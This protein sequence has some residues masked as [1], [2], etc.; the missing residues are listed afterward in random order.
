MSDSQLRRYITASDRLCTKYFDAKAGHLLARHLLQRRRLY[1]H[2][3]E[4]GDWRT[5]LAVLRDE[6]ELERLYPTAGKTEE[7][8][9]A[10]PPEPEELTAAE[11]AQALRQLCREA[12]EL[13]Q[14][15][16]QD[17]AASQYHDPRDDPRSLDDTAG[18]MIPDTIEDDHHEPGP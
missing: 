15:L 5:A 10:P 1:A 4:A 17:L 2:A 7:P 14:E 12:P 9:P 18:A 13:A 6:A 3:M 16:A 8:P 11:R